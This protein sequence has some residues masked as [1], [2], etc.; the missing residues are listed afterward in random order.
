MPGEFTILFVREPSE[1]HTLD[2]NISGEKKSSSLYFGV[3][4]S[5][6]LTEIELED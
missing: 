2:Q 6:N 4:Y 5:K 1:H 3:I